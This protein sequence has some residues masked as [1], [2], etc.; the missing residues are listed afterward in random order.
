VLNHL[1]AEGGVINTAQLNSAAGKSLES[2]TPY[3]DRQLRDCSSGSQDLATYLIG[4]QS[5]LSEFSNSTADELISRG[6]AKHQGN[7]LFS[8]CRLLEQQREDSEG[9]KGSLAKLFSLKEDYEANIIGVLQRRIEQIEPFDLQLIKFV[10]LAIKALSDEGP[11]YALCNLSSIEERAL[12]HVW[13]LESSDDK[14]IPS[15]TREY[16]TKGKRRDNSTVRKMIE[17][18]EAEIPNDRTNQLVFLK[19]LTGSL[20]NFESKSKY[21][22]KDTYVLLEAIHGFRNREEHKEAENVSYGAAVV[23]LFACV[24]LLD[25]LARE[26]G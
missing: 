17:K 5:G 13:N 21:T 9:G 6:F 22:S 23:T 12:K 18:G 11:Q 14:K 20:P 25:L 2:V 24:E 10:D 19:L 7:K 26:R 3:I 16:W 1:P 4:Q 15:E 8:G